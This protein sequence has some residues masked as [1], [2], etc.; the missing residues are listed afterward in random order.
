M[1]LRHL[2]YFSI[3]GEELHFGRAAQRLHISQPSLSIQIRELEEELS[4]R[5]LARTRRTVELTPAGM[6]F[7]TDVQRLLGQLGQTIRT[8]QRAG[9]GEIGRLV[10][11]FVLSATCSL[12]P[13]TLRVFRERFPD[14]ELDLEETTTGEGLAALTEGHLNLC[15]VRLPL[16]NMDEAIAVEPV[17]REKLILALPEGH[18][19]ETREQVTLRDLAD[20]PFIIFPRTQG[21]GFYDHLVSLCRQAGFSPRIAQEAGQMQTILS[22]VAAGLGIALI[23]ATVQSLRSNNVTYKPLDQRKLAETGIAMI[24]RRHDVSPMLHNF[25]Q[26]V[27]EQMR[28]APSSV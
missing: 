13:E 7:H 5:L 3:L 23:P 6:V 10:I 22:L 15:F 2:R 26:V 17:L 21:T 24:W 27:R 4:V 16:D 9:R 18:Y 8:A 14:V 19:L 28:S 11:G 1:E 25:M 20:E 12:L